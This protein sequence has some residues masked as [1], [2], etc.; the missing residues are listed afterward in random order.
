[1]KFKENK[2]YKFDYVNKI[3]IPDGIL[4]GIEMSRVYRKLEEY[5]QEGDYEL[6]KEIYPKVSDAIGLFEKLDRLPTFEEI[7]TYQDKWKGFFERQGR[8]KDGLW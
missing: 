6:F 8:I 7:K 5:Y 1:M 3:D 2:H 4:L